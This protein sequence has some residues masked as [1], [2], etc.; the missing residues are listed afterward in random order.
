MGYAE[1]RQKEFDQNRFAL[2]MFLMG[3]LGGHLVGYMGDDAAA[4]Y[5]LVVVGVGL[6]LLR[7][8]PRAE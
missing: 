5:L 6:M 2:F 1:Q 3:F 8:K 7:T 4:I